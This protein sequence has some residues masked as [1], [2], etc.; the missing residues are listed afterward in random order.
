MLIEHKGRILERMIGGCREVV[1]RGDGK[2][3]SVQAEEQAEM[4]RRA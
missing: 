2:G 3:D 1:E 4:R